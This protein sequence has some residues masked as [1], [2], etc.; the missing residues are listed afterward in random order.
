MTNDWGL[1]LL[2]LSN[3]RGTALPALAGVR[4]S[5]H[6]RGISTNWH[7]HLRPHASSSS[8]YGPGSKAVGDFLAS[9]Y[10]RL[11][12]RTTG[13]SN[14]ASQRSAGSGS[15]SGSEATG[16]GRSPAEG[17]PPRSSTSTTREDEGIRIRMER[18]PSANPDGKQRSS[19]EV[20]V[21]VE[22]EEAEARKSS[23]KLRSPS[24]PSAAK[25]RAG[26]FLAPPGIAA[27]SAGPGDDE[28]SSGGPG[29]GSASTSASA[30]ASGS[31]GGHHRRKSSFVP[32]RNEEQVGLLL[33][34]PVAYQIVV[35]LDLVLR[36][37]WSLKLSSHLQHIVQLE[38]GVFAV[39]ALEIV[40][41]CAWTFLRVEWEFVKQRRVQ[42]AGLA[43]AGMH[44]AP[45]AI[46]RR[47][48]E[49]Q[50]R[51][52]QCC[53]SDTRTLCTTANTI[54]HS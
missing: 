50:E 3:W 44:R 16:T 7:H 10:K 29:S 53:Y 30:S 2:K 37:L 26:N 48:G 38:A 17:A 12:V 43:G 5:L 27:A 42:S 23:D 11:S 18:Q 41:R 31:G 36:F 25:S 4:Q 46:E 20:A 33:F 52:Y 6:K 1:D 47:G 35:L 19:D 13:L 39:E 32:L 8:S 54:S 22:E 28:G 14:A 24:S 15:G 21:V 34:H 9:S 40:R 51:R 45:A 49:T